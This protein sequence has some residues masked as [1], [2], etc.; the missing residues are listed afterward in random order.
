MR[1]LLAV[2]A[3]AVVL[4]PLTAEAIDVWGDQWGTWTRDNSPYNVIGE[5]R[6]PPGEILTI[7]PGVV[8]NFRGHYK[9]IV[10]NS[11][12]LLA[13]GTETDSIYFTTDDPYTGWHSIRFYYAHPNSQVS[14]CVLEYGR[15]PGEGE[16]GRG[17]AIY[18]HYSSP[19]ITHNSIVN[20]S[21]FH[22]GGVLSYYGSPTISHNHIA[23][24]TSKAGS[25]VRPWGGSPVITDNVIERN[26]AWA[27]GGAI[28]CSYTDAIISNNIFI[29]NFSSEEGGAI[30]CW[31]GNPTISY[32]AI[33]DNFAGTYGGGIYCHDESPY[34]TPTIANNT[35]Y[36]NRAYSG[37]GVYCN[38]RSSPWIVNTILWEN[39]ASSG[40]EIYKA[41]GS[42]PMVTYCDVRGGWPGEG[43]IDADPLFVDPE[44]GDFHLQWGSPCI[45]TG[46]PDSPPDPDG[47]RVDMG[48]FYFPQGIVFSPREFF[49][50]LQLDTMAEK[51]L[52]LRNSSS[53]DTAAFYLSSDVDWVR[54]LPDS[55]YIPPDSSL[56]VSVTFD[57]TD[58]PLGP[59]E[60][61]IYLEAV[62]SYGVLDYE[63][64]V[65]ASVF[66]LEYTYVCLTPD[67]LPIVI[68]P[69][70]GSFNCWAQVYN[71]SDFLYRFD[72]WIDVTLPDGTTHG[73]RFKRENFR[74]RPHYSEL[75]YLTQNVPAYAPPGEYSYNFKMGV[76]PDQ[77]D[78]QDSFS[79]TKL[80]AGLLP[81]LARVTSWDLY[82]WDEEL[83]TYLGQG[84]DPKALNPTEYSLSQNYPNPFN[85]TT[86][87]Q[88]QLAEDGQVV[89]EVCNLFGQ[90]VATLVDE[91]Q[92]AGYRSVLWDASK[93][94]SGLYFYRLT[95]GDYTE[96]RRMML[97]K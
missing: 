6:V 59:N 34:P 64:P 93:V 33:I 90:K 86:T 17:G 58:L 10:D 45:D 15:A 52:S 66:S 77:V 87:I 25:A 32:N 62:T 16:D 75:R 80:D 41:S 84:Y 88:Y 12:T 55:G 57:G 96:T 40:A 53:S 4:F 13:V 3:M 11:A 69:E 27:W 61:I 71:S 85:A 73:P 68:P 60:A 24:N 49:F 20:N 44:A 46:D 5:I 43:N 74:F 54:F 21:A 38:T 83:V 37:G 76:F 39:T 50:N 79:F 95:A 56:D 70:G 8:V 91:R 72:I 18:C 35:I 22:C 92:G 97:V 29:D 89:L 67:S 23:D 94:S 7:E 2:L 14:Y 1:V 36:G 9:F 47:T 82:G 28:F 30:Y 26:S 42:N 63:I 78:Y 51:M 81:D 31:N 65:I 19:T 48:A